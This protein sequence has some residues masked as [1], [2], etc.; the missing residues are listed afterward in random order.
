MN[1]VT[2]RSFRQ[3]GGLLLL[4]LIWGSTWAAIRI[5][6]QC[7]PVLRSV[8]LRFLIASVVL[9]LVMKL[10]REAF[11]PLRDLPMLIGFSLVTIV[12]PFN[13]IAWSSKRV[14]SGLTSVLFSAS[15]LI[16]LLIEF[17][18]FSPPQRPRFNARLIFGLVAG[19]SGIALIMHSASST[20]SQGSGVVGIVL[21]VVMGSWSSVLAQRKLRHLSPLTVSAC[22]STCASVIV[23]AA[24]LFMDRGRP[25]TWT[26]HA[27]SALLF[28]GLVSSALG[29]FLFYWLLRDVR[30]YQ[31][32]SRYLLMPVIAVSE[33]V[34]FLGETISFA[35][36]A[37][38]VC[39]L[40]SLV[41]ILSEVTPKILPR[42][43]SRTGAIGGT[44]SGVD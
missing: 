19:L 22:L 33:G 1:L 41:P 36:V 12:V 20:T 13:I 25:S 5:S 3:L 23:G 29:F 34:L 14:S 38:A 42:P 9:V 17:V 15:P 44:L 43:N 8:A 16:V 24:S 7:M 18:S 35:F 27:V 4:S 6:V 11:P 32:A 26:I 21:V 30:P 37:G 39:I 40:V 28:L 2:L 10:R 31:L